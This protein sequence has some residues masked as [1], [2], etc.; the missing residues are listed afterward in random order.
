MA[1][2]KTKVV[3][4]RRKRSQKTNYRKRLR[5]LMSGKDRLVL[6]FS[7]NAITAQII[8]YESK[9]DIVKIGVNSVSLAKHGW[10][11]TKK[12]LPASYLTGL[13]LAKTAKKEGYNGELV[14]DIGF[15]TIKKQGRIFAVLRGALD[16]GLQVSYGDETIF[17]EEDAL[18]GKRI[19]QYAQKLKSEEKE[20]YS[21]QFSKY[22]A[23]SSD[24][25]KMPEI[26]LKVKGELLG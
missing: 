10:N 22:I 3:Q 24:P 17:P 18:Q 19:A 25:T 11:Y 2:K 13:L 12:N 20:V 5:L 6:R 21:K 14:L 16:G 1:S 26:F 23:N 7:G 9:G 4:F 8:S 15:Q